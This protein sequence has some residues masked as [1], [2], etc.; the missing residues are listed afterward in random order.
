MRRRAIRREWFRPRRHLGWRWIV[1]SPE[2]WVVTGLFL[3][4]VVLSAV[5]WG[6]EAWRAIVALVVVFFLVV[7][8]TGDPP[9]GPR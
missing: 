7:I 5:I 4:L 1:T 6:A 9:G 2:G 3:L 8:L